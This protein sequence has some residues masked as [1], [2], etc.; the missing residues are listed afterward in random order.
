MYQKCHKQ[1]T[2]SSNLDENEFCALNQ[3]KR[4]TGCV[5]S[6]NKSTWH[7]TTNFNSIGKSSWKTS[8]AREMAQ[9][10]VSTKPS[11]M[12]LVHVGFVISQILA[13]SSLWSDRILPKTAQTCFSDTLN[14]FIL[15]HRFACKLIHFESLLMHHHKKKTI[16][17]CRNLH[18]LLRHL[19]RCV[20]VHPFHTLIC[21][22]L[23]FINCFIISFSS[24]AF[25]GK[26]VMI[27][28]HRN[29][30]S[31]LLALP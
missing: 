9:L 2:S 31:S 16:K 3:Q 12:T 11:P 1:W 23:E 8:E 21:W 30:T 25:L 26:Q 18:K 15:S 5:K 20:C 17:Y 29:F 19:L 27:N 7:P 22:D 4:F 24:P 13:F 28:W 14:H 6:K 10:S